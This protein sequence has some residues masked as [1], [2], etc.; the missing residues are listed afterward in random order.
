[1]TRPRLSHNVAYMQL[2]IEAVKKL[3]WE[4]GVS[5][6]TLADEAGISEMTLNHLEQGK[7]TP[8]VST[9]KKLADALGVAVADITVESNGDEAVA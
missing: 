9:V 8:R 1:M 7:T 5:Q 2:D 3:R 4:R 6:E